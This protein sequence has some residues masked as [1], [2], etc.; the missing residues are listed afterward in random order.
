[1]HPNEIDDESAASRKKKKEVLRKIKKEQ[2]GNH[3]F[4]Y[5]RKHVGKGTNGSLKILHKKDEG[6]RIIKTHNKRK[7][8]RRGNNKAQHQTFFNGNWTENVSR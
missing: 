3:D 8:H 1:M 7:K 4:H 2:T 6:M 5:M